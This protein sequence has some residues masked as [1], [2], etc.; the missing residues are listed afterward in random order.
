[1]PSD[2]VL[3]AIIGAFV[4]LAGLFLALPKIRSEARK[5][6]AEA[7]SIEWHTLK[8]EIDRLQQRLSEQEQKIA[9]LERADHERADRERELERENRALKMKVGRLESRIR[10][11]EN[12]FKVGPISPEMQAQL[13]E[14]DRTER[15]KA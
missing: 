2:G 11:M 15:G 12:I 8:N 13:D 1:M 4:T 10:A 5:S 9:T 7:S 6:N 14:L 3:G